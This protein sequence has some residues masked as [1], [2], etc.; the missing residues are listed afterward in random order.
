MR[1]SFIIWCVL[2]IVCG[3][4]AMIPFFFWN[5]TEKKQ[6]EMARELKIKAYTND[7]EKGE[8][9]EENVKEA[10]ELG[11]LT[12]EQ[13]LEM[14]FASV[15]EAQ[16]EEDASEQLHEEQTLLMSQMQ[17]TQSTDSAVKDADETKEGKAE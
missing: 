9:D 17:D 6:L 4:L 13:A 8:L 2:G 3:V 10:V 14:G 7:L 11:V 16:T 1:S 15:M 12:R 5:L